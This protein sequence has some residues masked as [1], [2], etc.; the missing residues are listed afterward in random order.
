MT[1]GNEQNILPSNRCLQQ[2][3][4]IRR[5]IRFSACLLPILR[6]IGAPQLMKD[7]TGNL[8][9]F[10]AGVQRTTDRFATRHRAGDTN[11]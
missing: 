8:E 5:D 9:I 11:A 7:L 6:L 4:N 1:G 2:P 3:Q 10:L